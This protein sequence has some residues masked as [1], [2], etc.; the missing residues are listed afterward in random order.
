MEPDIPENDTA[1]D[2][3]NDTVHDTAHE[4]PSSRVDHLPSGGDVPTDS[5]IE[6]V[7]DQ[8]AG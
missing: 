3:E 7:A 1:H 8:E 2:T 4:D 6:I 5:T